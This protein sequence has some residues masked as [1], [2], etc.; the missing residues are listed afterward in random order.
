MR[1]AVGEDEVGAACARRKGN[2]IPTI[3]PPERPYHSQ[4]LVEGMF[5][6]GAELLATMEVERTPDT[7]ARRTV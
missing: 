7:K 5:V 2:T 6:R 4:L 1:Q 3:H